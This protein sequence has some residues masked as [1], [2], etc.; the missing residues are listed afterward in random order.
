MS[1][2]GKG[3][4]AERIAIIDGDVLFM[5]RIGAELRSVLQSS[6]VAEALSRKI[7]GIDDEV[8]FQNRLKTE[9]ESVEVTTVTR[10]AAKTYTGKKRGRK[11]KNLS[12]LAD[13]P[14]PEDFAAQVMNSQ[15]NEQPNE[16]TSGEANSDEPVA[17]A[18]DETVDEPA[19]AERK[20]PRRMR[21]GKSNVESAG[22]AD[23]K[24]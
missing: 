7:D 8:R 16:P 4:I 5:T 12:L 15:Q 11:P 14:S 22:S 2:T 13:N 24:F 19:V 23:G 20:G 9:L 3:T 17:Q 21:A 18:A 1:A 6:D 10:A